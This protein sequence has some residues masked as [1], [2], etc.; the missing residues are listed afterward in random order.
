MAADSSHRSLGFWAFDTL[1][2]NAASTAQTYLQKTSA[3]ACIL[4]ELRLRASECE[5][6]ERTAAWAKWSLSAEP[7]ADTDAGSTSAGVGVAVRSHLGLAMPRRLLDF[8]QLHSRVQVRWMGALCRGG[9]HLVSV[10]LW[11]SEGLSQRNLDLLQCLAGV[12][13]AIRGPWLLAGDFNVPP[14]S[15]RESGWLTLVKGVVHAPAMAA[16]KGRVLD[17]F[18][19]SRSLS[20]A[21]AAVMNIEDAGVSP[22][23]PVRLLLRGSPRSVKI[24]CL[25]APRRFEAQLPQGCPPRPASY[26]DV[27]DANVSPAVTKDNLDGLSVLTV[28]SPIS[29]AWTVTTGVE[30]VGAQMAR[31]SCGSQLWDL[32]G[33]L[34]CVHHG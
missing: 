25:A 23:S 4:Q 8:E 13:A 12:L 31:R 5:Q 10:Y 24:R 7:A 19:C 1:N 6:A 16:C 9:L 2:G 34:F 33:H 27:V 29:V 26:D 21:V 17:Y 28:S 18:V 30:L 32:L 3:D 22:H 14:E 15:L 11:T 20:S